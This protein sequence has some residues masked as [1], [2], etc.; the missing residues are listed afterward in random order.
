MIVRRV[1]DGFQDKL[2]HQVFTVDTLAT[3][4]YST[5]SLLVTCAVPARPVAAHYTHV[6]ASSLLH[7]NWEEPPYSKYKYK[8]SL[9]IYTK[10]AHY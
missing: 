8:K 3:A 5:K 9:A 10:N 4:N 6:S 2:L 7:L 1:E